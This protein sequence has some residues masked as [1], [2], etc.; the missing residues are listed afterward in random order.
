MFELYASLWTDVST[1]Q[2]TRRTISEVVHLF[3][4][5]TSVFPKTLPIHFSPAAYNKHPIS[6]AAPCTDLVWT[7]RHF[8]TLSIMYR[9][10]SLAFKTLHNMNL[11]WHLSISPHYH[12]I[13]NKSYRNPSLRQSHCIVSKTN[14]AFSY[15]LIFAQ[16]WIWIWIFLP[17]H[18]FSL[19]E[20]KFRDV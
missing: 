4:I 7:F 14:F 20:D 8:L 1:G 13:D 5:L 3:L 18:N 9:W 12:P 16:D 15:S 19:L 10:L 6:I 17:F 2:M 11:I